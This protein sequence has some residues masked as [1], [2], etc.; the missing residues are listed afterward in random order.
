MVH[1]IIYFFEYSL[2][3]LT[4]ML[5]NLNS[6]HNFCSE[7]TDKVK[8]DVEEKSEKIYQDILNYC[9]EFQTNFIDDQFPHCA[10]SIG[11]FE[12][13]EKNQ[14]VDSI[15][16]IEPN[17]IVTDDD[18]PWTV[19]NNPTPS[20]I[21]QS[22][23]VGDC[24]LMCAMAVI[25]E[26]PNILDD[27]FPSKEYSLQGVYRV[28]LCIE[29]EWKIIIVDDY[30]PCYEGNEMA[31]AVGRR[32]Q[33]W[34]PLIEKAAAKAVG[35]YAMLHGALV[36]QGLSMLTGAACDHY[37]TPE[38]EADVETFWGRLISAKFSGFIMCC[39]IGKDGEIKDE[40]LR[41]KGLLENHAYSILDVD[42]QYGF[43]LLRIRNPWG[44]FVWN[45]DWSNNWPNWPAE[46]RDNLLTNRIQETGAFWIELGD[47]IKMFESVTICKLRS[48]WNEFRHSQII[49]IDQPTIQ[50]N[51]FETCEISLEAFQK[52]SFAMKTDN[53]NDMM[54]S[55]HRISTDGEIGAMIG[56]SSRIAK[57]HLS[58]SEFLLNPGQYVIM[59]FNLKNENKKSLIM[60]IVC[61]SSKPI[62][63]ETI[64]Q[65]S[66]M[67]NRAIRKIVLK[68]GIVVNDMQSGTAIR[69]LTHKFCGMIIMADN[70]LNN[71]WLHLRIDCSESI[72]IQSTRNSLETNDI[73]PPMS[74]GIVQVLS[75][76]D[77]MSQFG[78]KYKLKKKIRRREYF[79][80]N[81]IYEASIIPDLQ[82]YPLL[83]DSDLIHTSHSLF[84]DTE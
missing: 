7:D 49:G 73:I 71:R 37:S 54:F 20:D 44:R 24:W 14:I 81:V 69:T 15:Q 29:G 82:N 56:R 28:K 70:F 22:A 64:R 72:N 47:F 78:V 32:N 31:M 84:C 13:E 42:D 45:G 16:W 38:D 50:L 9:H 57:S 36:T 25:A 35:S 53:L 2:T 62:F 63:C 1:L 12:K 77:E 3:N 74:Y 34:V 21:E 52:G 19:L 40:E 30:L 39:S 80:P 75:K 5:Q 11:V 26:R 55:L 4:A 67:L 41:A 23:L 48:N 33:L 83:D 6:S 58:I 76:I 51:V 61:H 60:N 79:D 17:H 66:K 8:K 59:C 27:I 10:R 46:M 43:R 68:D 65:T 18:G